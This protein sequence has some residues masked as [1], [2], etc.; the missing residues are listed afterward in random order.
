MAYIDSQVVAAEEE[1]NFF[2]L[3]KFADSFVDVA[4]EF[5]DLPEHSHFQDNAFLTLIISQEKKC[6]EFWKSKP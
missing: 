4:N 1:A 3:K 2:C 5:A 6:I